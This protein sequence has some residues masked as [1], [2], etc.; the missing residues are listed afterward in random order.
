VNVTAS[1]LY[2]DQRRDNL[3]LY[4]TGRGVTNTIPLDG[5]QK[6]QRSPI[7]ADDD[8]LLPNL[9]ITADLGGA[10]LTSSSSYVR[11]RWNYNADFSYFVQSALGLPDPFGT[12]LVVAGFG[13][14]RFTS[15]IQEVRLASNGNGP[16]R[17]QFGAYY[18]YKKRDADLLVSSQNLATIVPPLIPLILPGG[19][20]FDSDNVTTSKQFAGF[21]ELSYKV[22]DAFEVTAGL[23]VTRF[24]LHLDRF[25][26]GLFNGGPSGAVDQPGNAHHPEGFAQ[27]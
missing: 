3:P 14:Q 1:V 19:V 27:I 21:G 7:G 6:T 4:Y 22:T 8:F 26:D 10:T 13:D 20:L 11:R 17:W 9:T 15:H 25:A 23:R 18:Q 5:F 12:P 2:Q 16:L 24:K